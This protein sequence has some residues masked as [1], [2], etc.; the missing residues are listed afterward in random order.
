MNET[1]G[2]LVSLERRFQTFSQQ[3]AIFVAALDRC[4]QMKFQPKEKVKT[5]AQVSCASRKM[6]FLAIY[7]FYYTVYSGRKA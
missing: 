6:N 1:R 7:C 2:I 3:Q 4:R 5:I